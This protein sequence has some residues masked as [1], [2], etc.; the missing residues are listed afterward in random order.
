MNPYFALA[1][2][3]GALLL[4]G[5]I[6]H[7]EHEDRFNYCMQ[8]SN[9]ATDSEIVEFIRLCERQSGYTLPDGEYP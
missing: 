7:R 8:L 9:A 5:H 2:F 3:F 6:E 4:V 1:T